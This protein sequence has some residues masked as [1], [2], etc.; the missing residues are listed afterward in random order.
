MS[1]SRAND[2]EEAVALI[3]QAIKKVETLN[4]TPPEGVTTNGIVAVLNDAIRR[5]E[6]LGGE[7]GE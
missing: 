6:A 5:I 7:E 3:Q 1:A 4:R 2:V